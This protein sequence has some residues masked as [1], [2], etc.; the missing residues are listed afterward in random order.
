M[1]NLQLGAHQPF[2]TS[3]RAYLQEM[4]EAYSNSS[5]WDTR[6][7]VLSVM[8]GVASFGT[9]SEFIPGLTQYRYT[10]ASLHRMQYGRGAPVPSQRTPRIKIDLQQLDHFLGFIT[11]PHLV[12]D[13]PFW[14]EEFRALFRWDNSRTKRY[15]YDDSRTYCNAVYPVFHRDRLQGTQ[16]QYT[17]EDF[18]GMQCICSE[19][20][21]GI[22][23]FRGRGNTSIWRFTMYC[24]RHLLVTS[25]WFRLGSY[26]ERL[27]QG[28][29]TLPKGRLQGI[30]SSIKLHK[31]INKLMK[32]VIFSSEGDGGG[33]GRRRRHRSW[34]VATSAVT[35]SE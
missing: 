4:A 30:S 3:E 11:S 15:P 5:S 14:R 7:Q 16:S 17:V 27:A 8:A 9:I 10:M 28:R 34:N 19:I 23:L 35:R 33:V 18:E 24:A 25:W 29:K 1:V 26:D 31:Y 6:R 12:Q 32:M 2:L 20:S 22:R 21:P 13:L